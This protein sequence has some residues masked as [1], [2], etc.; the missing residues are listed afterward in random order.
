MMRVSMKPARLLDQET[1]EVER[2]IPSENT[3]LIER[4]EPDDRETPAFEE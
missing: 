3:P 2:E 4:I 1:V